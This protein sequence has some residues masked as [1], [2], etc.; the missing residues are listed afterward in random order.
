[1]L[2]LRQQTRLE[3]KVDAYFKDIATND[4]GFGSSVPLLPI[5]SATDYERFK[6]ELLDDQYKSKVVSNNKKYFNT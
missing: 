1:M 5:G 6:E 3:K 2:I 4:G